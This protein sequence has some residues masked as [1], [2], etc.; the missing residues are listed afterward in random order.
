MDWQEINNKFAIPLALTSIVVSVYGGDVRR[1]L[2][3]GTNVV[4]GQWTELR[5]LDSSITEGFSDNL[6]VIPLFFVKK[7]AQTIW[8][9]LTL[10]AILLLTYRH[11]RDMPTL[12]LL[13]YDVLLWWLCATAANWFLFSRQVI[14]AFRGNK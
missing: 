5:K 12:R 6:L 1:S 10:I 11:G 13:V 4:R 8:Q 14:N 7:A 2:S 9:A 3:R